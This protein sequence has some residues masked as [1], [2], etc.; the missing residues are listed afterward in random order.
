MWDVFVFLLFLTF[1]GSPQLPR[2]LRGIVAGWSSV[3]LLWDEKAT[4]AAP[5]LLRSRRVGVW[6][7]WGWRFCR[8]P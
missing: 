5:D 2:G 3:G 6:W 4:E 1:P 8:S 7:L